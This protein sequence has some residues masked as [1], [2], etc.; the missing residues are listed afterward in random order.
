[1]G[2]V[3]SRARE[4]VRALL[5]WDS[6][7]S[8]DLQ[9]LQGIHQLFS[10][11]YLQNALRSGDHAVNKLEHLGSPQQS[12]IAE[13]VEDGEVEQKKEHPGP[14][15][16][17][18]NSKGLANDCKAN[19]AQK[20]EH[21]DND[22][23]EQEQQHVNNNVDT[24]TP[25]P[26][27]NTKSR[28]KS[29]KSSMKLMRMKNKYRADT[30]SNAERDNTLPASPITEAGITKNASPADV[31]PA[32][33]HEV[34]DVAE[35]QDSPQDSSPD[36]VSIL[37]I[38][39]KV[40]GKKPLSPSINPLD[41]N[42]LIQKL[43]ACK[44]DK[45][46]KH[47]KMKNSEIFI[48]CTQAKE[49]LMQQPILLEINPPVR[50][51]GDIHGQFKDLLRLFDT[52]GYPPN[53][54]YLFLGDYVDRGKQSLETIL[55]LLC[56]KIKYPENLFMLRGNHECASVNRVY[57]FYD[58]CKRKCN[59]KVWRAFTDLFDCLPVSAIVGGA[60]IRK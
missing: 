27:G 23:I 12:H 19:D 9:F 50:I 58:E 20:S 38:K 24:H 13:T 15:E 59:L 32:K 31:V 10:L 22:K 60:H 29:R 36:I 42:G 26:K 35:N 33:P 41:I 7:R 3:A 5:S 47:H 21:A 4:R 1:M 51:V 6:N 30:P 48:I 18:G 52:C 53:A 40:K 49:I 39:G 11:Q 46:S 17:G 37:A 43:L 56:Y 28:K 45:Y 25:V 16:E 2:N 8:S 55:L 14:P 54:N 34:L 57:G 44:S